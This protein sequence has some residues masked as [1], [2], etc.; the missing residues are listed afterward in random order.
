MIV[1]KNTE[2]RANSRGF[3]ALATT[4]AIGLM[5]ASIHAQ[6]CDPV[7]TDEFVAVDG[8]AYDW[9]G[10]S[11]SISGN[12]A[13]TGAH[14]NEANGAGSGAAYV[15]THDAGAWTQ[16]AK[17]LPADGQPSDYFGF[18]VSICGD[19]AIVGTY[20]DNDNGPDSGSAYIFIRTDGIWT[21]QAKILPADGVAYDLFG[22]SVS[23]SGDTVIVGAFG[24]DDNGNNASG[25]AYVFTRTAGVWTQ[26][27]KFTA[28]DGARNDHFGHAVTIEG[29]TAVVGA[30]ND[31]DNGSDSGSAYVFART[32]ETWVQQAKLLPADGAAEEEFGAALAIDGDTTLI[33]ARRGENGGSAYVFV[34]TEGTWTQQAKLVADDASLG[35]EFGVSVAINNNTA[36]I[37]ASW[38]DEPGSATG[39]AYVFTRTDGIWTQQA[40]L[41]PAVTTAYDHFGEF[42][43]FNGDTALIGSY[44]DDD[45]DWDS[46][47]I[48]VF[49]LGCNDCPADLTG[50]GSLDISDVV[51]FLEAYTTGNLIADLTSNGVIDISDV[52]AFLNSYNAGC[53]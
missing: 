41:L 13:V 3:H 27:A 47:S 2:R 8:T 4:L 9:F 14:W 40:K 26:Q 37:G 12:T 29:D 44:K 39:S 35:D 19:T 21:Q 30:R 25:S 7:E 1:S 34:H 42:V 48:Y 23:I 50:D 16:Q 46:G 6:T 33:G 49:D 11:V 22:Y 20:A 32:G 51:A 43:A 38:D 24:D 10:Y 36:L 52:I 28:S 5:T 53:P 15:F 17:L 18:S 31:N 45:T